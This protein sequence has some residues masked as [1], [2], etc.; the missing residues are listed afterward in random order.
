[1]PDDEKVFKEPTEFITFKRHPLLWLRFRW[2]K[3]ILRKDILGFCDNIPVIGT[4]EL[5]DA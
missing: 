5:K 4:E 2:Y 3:W 1:M